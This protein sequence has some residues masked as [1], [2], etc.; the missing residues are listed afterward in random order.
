MSAPVREKLYLMP[1]EDHLQQNI[2]VL[3]AGEFRTFNLSQDV[4]LYFQQHYTRKQALAGVVLIA[5]IAAAVFVGI[6]KSPLIGGL[7]S[8]AAVLPIGAFLYLRHQNKA[9]ILKSETNTTEVIDI[10]NAIKSY[11]AKEYIVRQ[12]KHALKAVGILW[13]AIN[14]LCAQDRKDNEANIELASKIAASRGP[15]HMPAFKNLLGMCSMYAAG[16]GCDYEHEAVPDSNVAKI[17]AIRYQDLPK[18]YA[19]PTPL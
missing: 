4:K 1:D 19:E 11:F 7:T 16:L 9:R 6:Y 5:I 14:E 2:R 10:W 8:I 13:N 12:Q 15:V 17:T 18:E 3:A